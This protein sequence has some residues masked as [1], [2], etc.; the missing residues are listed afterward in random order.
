II[1]LKMGVL[2]RIQEIENE[3]A[4][5]QKNKKTEYHIG[6]LKARLAKLRKEL[7]APKTSTVSGDSFEVQ[8][9]GDARVTFIGFPSVG[10]STLLSKITT[11]ESKA[12][13]HEFT[14]LDCIS[15]K[16]DYKGAKIQVLDLP[17]II[18]GAAQGVGRGK[19]VIGVART[20]DLIL[21]LLDPRR[22]EDRI[23]LEKELYD[24]G[25]RL[26]AKKPDVTV[27]I[28]NSGGVSVNTTV[29]LTKTD[30]NM[31]KL[32]FKEYKI[33]NC[34]IVIRDDVTV[35][36]I[37]DVISDSV[38]YINCLY[39]YNKIDSISYESLVY[40]GDLPNSVAIS[41]RRGWNFDELYEKIWEMIDLKRV[42]TKK[43]GEF[44]DLNNPLVI[45][46]E[47]TVKAVCLKL[48]RDF[49]QNFK[50]ALVWG[51]SAK[52]QPQKVGLNHKIADEDV[53]QVYTS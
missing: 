8:K 21:M 23:V 14:T 43:R 53:L 7:L 16:L 11:T 17:G 52:H 30:E 42:Y 36:E 50:Y 26:N 46:G 28:T 47:G 29:N 48:H 44:P 24:M 41:S 12:A 37:I 34:M 9:T 39:C 20:S 32:I 4:R 1:L 22:P 15:G 18:K 51:A 25:I 38:V 13:A 10:K 2:E 19:Q 45:K 5:T 3:M 27:T 31:I 33:N 35:D 40:H 49:V 6:C